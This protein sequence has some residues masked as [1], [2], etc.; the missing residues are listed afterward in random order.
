MNIRISEP[1]MQMFK[2]FGLFLLSLVTALAFAEGPQCPAVACDCEAFI[3]SRWRSV[4]KLHER[5]VK[6]LCADSA[7]TPQ[8]YCRLSG[9]SAKPVA[10]SVAVDDLPG[11][12]VLDQ[13]GR[14]QLL[15]EIKAAE[16]SLLEDLKF[17][18]R[19]L[20]IRDIAKLGQM[21]NILDRRAKALFHQ[22][23]L[24]AFNLPQHPPAVD[25]DTI[26]A[27]S[28]SEAAT[29]AG[30]VGDREAFWSA[31]ADRLM[32]F[33]ERLQIDAGQAAPGASAQARQ[34]AFRFARLAT[35]S[36]EYS[37]RTLAEAGLYPQAA[38]AME[39]SAGVA[40]QLTT[41]AMAVAAPAKH[42]EFY[43]EQAA[44][45][46]HLATYYWSLSENREESLVSFQNAEQVL[47]ALSGGTDTG[48]V[49]GA[50]DEAGALP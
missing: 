23:R 21:S 31:V 45:R 15:E 20:E 11:L 29:A 50:E 33:G 24:V 10:L 27:A 2:F 1:V 6:Q 46:W 14:E 28:D 12:T 9:P 47:N 18:E 44:A 41:R 38:A 5:E 16:W 36:L 48:E 37:A 42:L 4:C 25:K 19:Y 39:L 32:L 49:A 8:S 26:N 35:T 43:R 22:H 13:A 3:D 17:A 40:E 7:G 30:L 34:V